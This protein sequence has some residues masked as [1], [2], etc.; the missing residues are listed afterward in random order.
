MKK[1]VLTICCLYIKLI[2]MKHLADYITFLK[3]RGDFCFTSQQAMEFLHISRKALI[4]SLIR[5]RQKQEIVTLSKTFHLIITPEYYSSGCLPPSHFIAA[6]MRFLQ[7]PYYVALLS[8]AE[9]YGAA[10]QKVQV[11][12]VMTNKQ[13]NTATCGKIVIKFIYKKNLENVPTNT[14]NVPTGYIKVAAPEAVA[15]D[16]LMYRKV[17]GGINNI[18]TVLTELIDSVDADKLLQLVE[19]T[20]ETAWVQR[21]GFILEQLDP[22]ETK[23]RDK[24]VGMLKD[25]IKTK[26]PSYVLLVPGSAE[27]ITKNTPWKIK[28]NCKIESDI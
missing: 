6:Y 10:H 9:Y 21:L 14:F 20:N 5:L 19:T 23:N 15:M 18:A 13:L 27:K 8:A 3:T 26:N 16:L 17:A 11:F 7:L 1:M 28:V 2:R 25:F 4:M 12:Q 24:I 22:M